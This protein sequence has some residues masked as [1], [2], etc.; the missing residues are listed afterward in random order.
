MDPQTAPSSAFLS[1]LFELPQVTNH[2]VKGWLINHP[3]CP[4]ERAAGLPRLAPPLGGDQC[5]IS[6]R[7]VWRGR[8]EMKALN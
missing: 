4:T 7:P 1:F 8:R 6:A 3:S 5:L 2:T